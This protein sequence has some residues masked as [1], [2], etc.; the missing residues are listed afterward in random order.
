MTKYER[1]ANERGLLNKKNDALK[2]ENE[3]LREDNRILVEGLK[4]AK[5]IISCSDYAKT[6]ESH[7]DTGLPLLIESALNNAKKQNL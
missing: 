6:Y 1:A 7:K 3:K 5:H 2:A 4:A